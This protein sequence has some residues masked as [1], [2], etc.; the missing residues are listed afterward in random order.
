MILYLYTLC[1]CIGDVNE[2]LVTHLN[3]VSEACIVDKDETIPNYSTQWIAYSCGMNDA[4]IVTK[5]YC[6]ILA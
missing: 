3:Y 5:S 1:V 4:H 6:S 2:L